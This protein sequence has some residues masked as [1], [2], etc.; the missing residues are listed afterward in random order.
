MCCLFAEVGEHLQELLVLLTPPGGS[1]IVHCQRVQGDEEQRFANALQQADSSLSGTGWTSEWNCWNFQYKPVAIK[2]DWDLLQGMDHSLYTL[3]CRAETP[4][5]RQQGI[6]VI[7]GDEVHDTLT[8]LFSLEHRACT[9]HPTT[10]DK[11]LLMPTQKLFW[12]L[13]KGDPDIG[14]DALVDEVRWHAAQLV[15]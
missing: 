8:S 13:L 15:D 11:V 1:W 2:L 4:Y 9:I 6:A 10:D 3:H 12:L 7:N 5:A 14:D